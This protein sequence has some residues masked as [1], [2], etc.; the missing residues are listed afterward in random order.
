[1]NVINYDFALEYGDGVVLGG[2]IQE[3]LYRL[4]EFGCGEDG[5]SVFG[6]P[7]QVIGHAVD[8]SACF[9]IHVYASIDTI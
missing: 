6:H 5:F 4:A 7:V 8:I 3:V 9:C 2:H 1:M